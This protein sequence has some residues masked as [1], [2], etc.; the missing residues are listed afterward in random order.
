MRR[1]ADLS[2]LTKVIAVSLAIGAMKSADAVHPPAVSFAFLFV[3]GGKTYDFA[4]GPII[5]CAV[6]IAAQEL[7]TMAVGDAK[8]KTK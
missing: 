3:T 7:Y 1:P 5:G 6:L 2:A 8:Q 4:I